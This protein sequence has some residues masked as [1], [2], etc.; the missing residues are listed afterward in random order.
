MREGGYS[1]RRILRYWN[2][3]CL[4]TR[5]ATASTLARGRYGQPEHEMTVQ[6]EKGRTMHIAVVGV[7]SV[8]AFFGGRL[9]QTGNSSRSWP[10]ALICAPCKSPA[11]R[12]RAL[13][14]TSSFHL[15]MP[16]TLP[17]TSARWT[18]WC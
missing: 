10:G 4:S 16:Q 11:C 7:G 6:G 3:T 17:R 15:S 9:A 12:W 18:W 13:T 5:G 1:R 14:A 2:I 8:G